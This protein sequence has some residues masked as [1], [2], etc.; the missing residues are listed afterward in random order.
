MYLH[1][2]DTGGEGFGGL[3]AEHARGDR[4]GGAG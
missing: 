2:L 3:Q 1:V 4:A